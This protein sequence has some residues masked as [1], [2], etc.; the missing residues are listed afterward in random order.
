MPAEIEG[1]AW[2]AGS[3]RWLRPAPPPPATAA[4][5]SAG[6]PVGSSRHSLSQDGIRVAVIAFKA[7]GVEFLYREG[8]LKRMPTSR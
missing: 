2:W 4:R 8:Q 7:F 3:A 5:S 6:L 1:H